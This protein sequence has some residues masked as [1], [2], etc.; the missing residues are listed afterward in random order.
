MSTPAAMACLLQVCSASMAATGKQDRVL[1]VD[2]LR[3]AGLSSQQLETAAFY[4][5]QADSL[6][7][8]ACAGQQAISA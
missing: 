8:I 2:A 1:V 3:E 6:Y 7:S 4:A 5:A